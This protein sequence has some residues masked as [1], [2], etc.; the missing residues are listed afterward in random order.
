MQEKELKKYGKMTF[1]V[2]VNG[3][4]SVLKS[5]SGRQKDS[6]FPT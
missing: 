2:L 6:L 1:A 3:L 4:S 5:T